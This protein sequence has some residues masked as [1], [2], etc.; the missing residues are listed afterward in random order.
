MSVSLRIICVFVW[1]AL[2]CFSRVHARFV[3]SPLGI[4]GFRGGFLGVKKPRGTSFYRCVVL[5]VRIAIF[6]SLEI[7]VS[8]AGMR[9]GSM[10]N[11]LAVSSFLAFNIRFY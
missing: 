7:R 5:V 1:I 8:V 6:D 11:N 10:V 2:C 4:L 9:N 3:R